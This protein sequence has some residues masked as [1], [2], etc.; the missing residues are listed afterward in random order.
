MDGIYFHFLPAAPQICGTMRNRSREVY[1][2]LCDMIIA[3]N[4]PKEIISASA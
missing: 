3:T 4:V 2:F 1:F